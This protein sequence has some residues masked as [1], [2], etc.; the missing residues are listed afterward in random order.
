MNLM[1]GHY[2]FLAENLRNSWGKPLQ[3][4]GVAH[5]SRIGSELV[6]N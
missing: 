2:D 1:K 4:S 6:T 5:L 3:D